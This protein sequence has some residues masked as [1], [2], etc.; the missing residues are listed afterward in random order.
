[1]YINYYN[2]ENENENILSLKEYIE[3]TQKTK[4]NLVERKSKFYEFRSKSI[5]Y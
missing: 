4:I 2:D 1:M 5:F 3:A